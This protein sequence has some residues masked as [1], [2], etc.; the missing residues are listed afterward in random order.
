MYRALGRHARDSEGPNRAERGTLS[1]VV[2]CSPT[3]SY[4]TDMRLAVWFP[5]VPAGLGST[6]YDY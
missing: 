3:S 2:L 4:T 1:L 6:F 5:V